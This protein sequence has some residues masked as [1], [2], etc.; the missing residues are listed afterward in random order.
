[1]EEYE[2]L[3][4]EVLRS[5]FSCEPSYMYRKEFLFANSTLDPNT[6]SSHPLYLAVGMDPSDYPLAGEPCGGADH[7]GNAAEARGFPGLQACPQASTR[8]GEM[9]AG[10]QLQHPADE[11]P[12]E[13]PTRFHAL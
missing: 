1:M 3:A 6:C 5:V 9:P 4:S 12:P 8:S 2:K 11:A 13:Q 7:A 10:D